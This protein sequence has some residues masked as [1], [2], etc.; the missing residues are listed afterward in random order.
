MAEVFISYP[1]E[2]AK[3]VMEL[4]SGIRAKGIDVWCAE[5]KVSPDDDVK[6]MK[7]KVM[8]ALEDAKTVMG[9]SNSFPTWRDLIRRRTTPLSRA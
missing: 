2:A 3:N 5:E 9:T 8:S 7:A 4:V 6:A 1:H